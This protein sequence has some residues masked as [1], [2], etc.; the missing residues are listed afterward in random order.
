VPS[1]HTKVTKCA[2]VKRYRDERVPTS[3]TYRLA[4][5]IK[6]LEDSQ[7]NAHAPF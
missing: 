4:Y 6:T 2:V 1:A 3:I 5:R 7:T